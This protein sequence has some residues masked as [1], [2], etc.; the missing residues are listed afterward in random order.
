MGIHQGCQDCQHCQ[1]YDM[2]CDGNVDLWEETARGNEWVFIKVAKMV[3]AA[4]FMIWLYDG[5]LGSG[6]GGGRVEM[7]RYSGG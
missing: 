5:H 4:N 3:K 7:N 6:R 1:F 2:A